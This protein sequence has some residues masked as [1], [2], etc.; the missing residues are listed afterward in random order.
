MKA[1]IC[2]MCGASQKDDSNADYFRLETYKKEG[3]IPQRHDFC[4]ACWCDLY[5]YLNKKKSKS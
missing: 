5:D 2:D 4:R 3:E 1:I